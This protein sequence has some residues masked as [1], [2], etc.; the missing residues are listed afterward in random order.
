MQKA[1]AEAG[2]NTN[3]FIRLFHEYVKEPLMNN[4]N[5]LNKTGW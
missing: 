3:E 2:T 4:L 1:A 5:M